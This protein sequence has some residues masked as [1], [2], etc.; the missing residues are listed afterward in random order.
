MPRPTT[1]DHL[2]SAK[3]PLEMR[4]PVYLDGEPIERLEKAR[5]EVEALRTRHLA[6]AGS[7]GE[8]A[9]ADQL[10]AAEAERSAAEEAVRDSTAWFVL[11]KI[12]PRGRKRYE[13]MVAAHPPTP[14]QV[15]EAAKAGQERPPYNADTFA[16]ALLSMTCVEPIFTLE[17]ATELFDDWTITEVTEIFSACLAVNTGRRTVDLGKG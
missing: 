14:E 9:G 12:A 8:P 7:P 15:E 13:E 11:R 4:I 6:L 17:E 10:E 1:Y 5:E 3:K 2:K 16:P